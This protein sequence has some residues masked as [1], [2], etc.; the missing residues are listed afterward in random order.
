MVTTS[1]AVQANFDLKTSGKTW[2]PRR[3]KEKTKTKQA[4]HLPQRHPHL[5]IS[6]DGAAPGGRS[7]VVGEVGGHQYRVPGREGAGLAVTHTGIDQ[8]GA[9]TR[10]PTVTADCYVE[11]WGWSKKITLERS[12][13]CAFCLLLTWVYSEGMYCE[14]FF[15][16]GSYVCT[17]MFIIQPKQ[18]GTV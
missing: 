15:C 2:V 3:I 12:G 18:L 16:F 8:V 6:A 14:G 11:G 5:G 7:D 10:A 1:G 4:S 17:N 13:F 9:F